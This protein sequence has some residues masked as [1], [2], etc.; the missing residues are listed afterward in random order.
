MTT[1]RKD[2]IRKLLKGIE[3]GDPVSVAVVNEDK[4][5]QHNPQT[6]EG[7]EGLAQL[8]ARISKS[9]PRVNIVRIFQDGDYVFGHTEYDFSTRRVGFE[10]FRFEGNQAVEHWDNIQPRQ[11]KNALQLEMV[12]GP[13]EANDLDKTEENRS[14]VRDFVQTVFVN[15]NV[16]KLE[17]FLAQDDGF[18]Q[19]SPYVPV[20]GIEGIKKWLS[21]DAGDSKGKKVKYQKIHRVLAQG[22]FC[23]VVTEGT[24]DDNNTSFYD[25]YRVT[26]G[27]ITEHWDTIEEVPPKSE[28]KNNNGKF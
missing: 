25:M 11:A 10:V 24:L 1:N 9:N 4:Y 8:F 7:G 14:L 22:S 21:D 13:T 12:D 15:G 27:K 19:Y 5:I 23:L 20:D 3:T 28:W 26:N 6:R 18:T 16:D 17:D 2:L